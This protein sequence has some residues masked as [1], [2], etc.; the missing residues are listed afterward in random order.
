MSGFLKLFLKLSLASAIIM[1]CCGSA[2]AKSTIQ[3]IGDYTRIIVP[4]YA[5]GMAMSKNDDE[6]IKQL[7]ASFLM[8]QATVEGLKYTVRAERPDG[9]NYKS[10]PSGHAASAFS[11]AT[12]IH[13]R[14]GLEKAVIPYMLAGFTGYSRIYAKAHYFHDVVA[15]ALL[16]S[17]FT[18]MFVSEYDGGVQVQ[19][20]VEP[21]SVRL[22]LSMEF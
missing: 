12:F 21:D 5:L 1:N 7:A 18:W 14:Y 22:G 20:T 10:F 19:V 4:V 8:T 6:G 3:E 2:F 9:S 13:K 11:G 17:F 15:S 16:S